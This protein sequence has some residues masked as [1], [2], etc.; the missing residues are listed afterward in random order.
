MFS[1]CHFQLK[2]LRRH[3]VNCTGVEAIIVQNIVTYLS[4]RLQSAS[5]TFSK[6]QSKYM[7]SKRS[8][9]I[10]K[11]NFCILM[12]NLHIVEKREINS[13]SSC[14]T[15]QIFRE[16]NSFVTSLVK[17]LLS[18]FFLKSTIFPSNYRVY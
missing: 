10:L 8:F 14:I 6:E 5:E 9:N 18:R 2:S 12:H 15:K 1:S 7:K 16:I 13:L 11:W 4:G 17:T 3:T